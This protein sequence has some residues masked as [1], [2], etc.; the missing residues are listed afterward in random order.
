[1][2]RPPRRLLVALLGAALGPS[3]LGGPT[4]WAEP[5]GDLGALAP[6]DPEADDQALGDEPD[7]GGLD[8]RGDGDAG[9]GG[10]DDFGRAIEIEAIETVGNDVTS[11]RVIIQAL[12]FRPGDRIAAGAR[13]LR[14]ARFKVLALGFFRSVRLTMRRGTARGQ[15]V[16]VVVVEERGTL[17]LGRLWFGTSTSSAGW[18]GADLA[19]RNFL[20]RGLS[21]GGAAV[22]ARH[23]GIAGSRDQVAGEA[24]LA[25]A[26]VLGSPIGLGLALTGVRG[27]EPYRVAGSDDSDRASDFAAF[28]YRRLGARL[29]ASYDLTAFTQLTLGSRVERVDATLPAAPIRTLPSGDEVAL[30]LRLRPGASTIATLAF[31]LDRDTRRNPALP[32]VGT[33]LQLD[34]EGGVRAVLGDYHFVTTSARYERWWPLRRGAQ[35]IGMRLGAAAAFGDAPRFDRLHLGDLNR[36]VTPRALGLTLSAEP[37]PDLLGGRAEDEAY[38]DLG[39]SASVEFASRLFRGGDHLYGGDLFIAVGGWALASRGSPAALGGGVPADLFI[40]AGL[41]LDTEIGTFE[42]TFANA[43]GRVAL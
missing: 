15:V 8:A 30:D 23:G 10:L 40:D 13:R 42:L 2:S 12:P 19:D 43:F 27:S 21:L 41:R 33:R 5:A 3:A 29:T 16:I 34:V 24:R 38:G 25:A 18:L 22:Y 7:G 14:D 20:G 4:A 32:H 35:A 6:L 11:D 37:A 36:L 17:A 39:G 28:A 31:G 1:M 26:S 9:A